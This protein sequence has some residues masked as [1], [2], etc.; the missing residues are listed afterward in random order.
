MIDV[1][2]CP[3]ELTTL[4]ICVVK[5]NYKLLTIIH[6]DHHA[7]SGVARNPSWGKC[8]QR[9][10]ARLHGGLGRNHAWSA[11]AISVIF[12]VILGLRRTIQSLLF[13]M[14]APHWWKL[15]FTFADSAW[16]KIKFVLH[17][18]S[19]LTNSQTIITLS[20]Q[21]DVTYAHLSPSVGSD[22]MLTARDSC[23][24]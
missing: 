5:F 11:N 7:Y 10:S 17:E 13:T 3:A 19:L 22:K 23:W 6:M 20:K 8:G 12:T 2:Y 18:Y 1:I 9:G 4:R 15:D 24:Q 16:E 14:I 21:C